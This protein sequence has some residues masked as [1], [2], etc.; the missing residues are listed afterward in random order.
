MDGGWLKPVCFP[1][2]GVLIPGSCV[3]WAAAAVTHL[4]LQHVVLHQLPLP[5][6][7]RLLERT[8]DAVGLQLQRL[9]SLL[10]A[11]GAAWKWHR[12]G[13]LKRS[14]CEGCCNQ[15][16]AQASLCWAH[17]HAMLS[18]RCFSM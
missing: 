9:N 1:R 2:R 6:G 12:G 10:Q 5:G 18:L 17:A 16:Q 11:L 14:L 8:R 4:Q 15:T 13:G 3:V 7:N